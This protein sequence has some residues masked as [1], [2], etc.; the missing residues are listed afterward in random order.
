MKEEGIFS[1]EEY[2]HNFWG[3]KEGQKDWRQDNK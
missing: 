3:A 1:Q 2:V